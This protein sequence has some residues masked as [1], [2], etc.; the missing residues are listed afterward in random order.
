[1][2]QYQF[3]PS[4]MLI[5]TNDTEPHGL[6]LYQEFPIWLEKCSTFCHSIICLQRESNCLLEMSWDLS[7]TF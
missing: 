3:I 4:K 7:N 1:M 6:C 2:S 5:S